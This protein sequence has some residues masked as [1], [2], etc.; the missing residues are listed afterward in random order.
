MQILMLAA[1]K[2]SQQNAFHMYV[3][4]NSRFNVRRTV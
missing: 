4:T 2:Q 1:S 3:D